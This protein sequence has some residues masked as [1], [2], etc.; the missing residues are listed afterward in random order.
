MLMTV[1]FAYLVLCICGCAMQRRLLYFPTKLS[2]DAAAQEAAGGDFIS[3]KNASGQVIGW[4]IP[5]NGPSVGS[6]LIVHGNAGCAVNRDY[7]AQPI[8]EAMDADVF[9]LEYPGYGARAGSPGKKSFDAAAEEAF[10][11][12]PADAPKYIVSESIGTGVA[13]D[14]AKDH[15]KEIAGM[16][17]MVPYHNLASVAQHKMWFL[18]AYF[19]L[20]DRFNPKKSLED[21][22]G[23]VKFVVAGADEVIGPA[24]GLRLYK[25]YAGPKDLQ[26]VAGAH[27][28][29]VAAQ[30]PDWWKNVFSFWKEN[31]MVAP[32][33]SVTKR[34]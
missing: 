2:P 17:L 24:T 13:C 20:I 3:W 21:Y 23:P 7:L 19:I 26:I 16:A 14:L 9:V 1:F 22:R 25:S 34:G 18:P 4:E 30:P 6:V 27:H 8:H 31:E 29:D 15:P 32:N 28:N 11:L 5:A 12:L 33:T 10:Q